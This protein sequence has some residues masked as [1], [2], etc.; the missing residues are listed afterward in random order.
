MN[1]DVNARA[2]HEC[3]TDD[4]QGG[5]DEITFTTYLRHLLERNDRQPLIWPA[6]PVPNGNWRVIGIV[7]QKGLLDLFN[8]PSTEVQTEARSKGRQPFKLLALGN[9]GSTTSSAQD[10]GL[11]NA[12]NG[13][14]PLECGSRGLM[15][16]PRAPPPGCPDRWV[17][18]CR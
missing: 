16:S 17:Q 6:H 5:S 9:A 14:F 2:R 4:V 7:L 15:L 13:E 18:I 12:W 10:N 11:N 3:R 1:T 8:M